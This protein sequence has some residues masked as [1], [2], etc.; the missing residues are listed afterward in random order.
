MTIHTESQIEIN[1]GVDVG[2]SK[3][4]IVLHPPISISN[5]NEETSIKIVQVLKSQNITRIVT[6]ITDA[7]NMR[8]CLPVT[9]PTAHCRG[10]PGSIR[11]WCRP[12]VYW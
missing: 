2:K 5:L 12:S 11:R 4:D 7:T 10:Q 8:S 3:L 1:V 9:R 6:E